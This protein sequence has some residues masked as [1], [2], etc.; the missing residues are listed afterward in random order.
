MN[1]RALKIRQ[2]R[3]LSAIAFVQMT[4]MVLQLRSVET[5]NE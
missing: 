1:R 3:I 5:K 2:L 4:T